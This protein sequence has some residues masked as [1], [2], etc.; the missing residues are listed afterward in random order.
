MTLTKAKMV[1]VLLVAAMVA[2]AARRSRPHP[3]PATAGQPS[4]HQPERPPMTEPEA[5]SEPA[6][7]SLALPEGWMGGAGTG[8]PEGLAY[9]ARMVVPPKGEPSAEAT[10]AVVFQTVAGSNDPQAMYA[11]LVDGGLAG[12][13]ELLDLATGP[14]VRRVGRHREVPEDGT[15]PREAA[16]RQYYLRVPGTDDQ[17]VVLSF[18]TPTVEHEERLGA[19]FEAMAGTFIWT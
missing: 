5:V 2:T 17:I 8:T 1:S 13:V 3:G 11:E 9:Q 19:L 15:E 16:G 4:D 14:A 18:V 6:G 12:E 7:F 10:L